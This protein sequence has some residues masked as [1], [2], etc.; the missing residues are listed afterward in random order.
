MYDYPIAIRKLIRE[1]SKLPSLGERSATRLAYHLVYR[2]KGL[3]LSLADH[4]TEAMAKTRLCKS[5]NALTE[6]ELCSICQDSS[7]NR[8][9]LCIVEKPIDIFS[10]ERLGIFKGLY[11][12]L[13]GLWSPMKGVDPSDLKFTELNKRILELQPEEIIIATGSTLEGDATALFIASEIGHL[14]TKIT[15][16]A[17]GMPKGGE[18]EYADEITLQRALEGRSVL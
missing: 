6:S 7:R 18:L 3:G 10:I 4:L 17:Q 11:H 1:L 14:S 15:R 5:C 8:K 9:L 13:H 2:D 12:V 16:L